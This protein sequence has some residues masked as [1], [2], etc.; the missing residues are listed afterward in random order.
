[1]KNFKHY[2]IKAE[3][4]ISEAFELMNIN[5]IGAV[6]VVNDSEDVLGVATDGDIR[7]HLLENKNVNDEI[8]RCMNTDFIHIDSSTSRE[9]ILKLLDNSIKFIPVLDNKKLID[10]VTR[11]NIPLHSKKRV[12]ARAKS[13]VRISF[14]GGGT[15]LTHYFVNHGGAV[16][17]A[18]I[19]MY[20]HA[21][22]RKREDSRVII[23]SNDLKKTFC[24]D[25][26]N[27]LLECEDSRLLIALIRLI[28]PDFGFELIV[29]SDFPMKSGLGGSAVVLSAIIGCF[30]EFREVRWDSYEIAEL[31]FQAE[32]ITIDLA[33]GWQDQYA[34]VFGGF[35]FMEFTDKQNVIHPLRISSKSKLE[36]EENLIL[37]YTHSS[38]ESGNIHNDQK[39]SYKTNSSIQELVHANRE[40]TYEMKNLLLKNNISRFG[41][42][43]DKG[44]RLKRRFSDGI[45]NKRLDE[46]Y[47]LALSCGAEGGKLLGAGGGGYFLFYTTPFKKDDLINSLEEAGCSVRP[48]LFDDD[49]LQTWQVRE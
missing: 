40:L 41:A 32:R 48:I 18:T 35:N 17:N 13:P 47:D 14:G 8:S 21:S 12:I 6:V 9:K 23:R 36:L 38:H 34:T 42:Y 33:G 10:I 22:L 39:K 27:D 29:S 19:K 15:D 3:G 31:A 7:R 44:W 25:S 11:S 28:S 37:C 4:K 2:V 46:I 20:S 30:N 43:L 26:L 45:T 24:A 16:M 49:G 1:M 5:Q